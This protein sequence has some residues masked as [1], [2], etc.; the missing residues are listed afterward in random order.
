MKM[1]TRKDKEL[2]NKYDFLTISLLSEVPLGWLNL[3]DQMSAEIQEELDRSGIIDYTVVQAKEKFG[4]L[5]W[6]DFNG[7]SRINEIIGKYE[8]LSASTCCQ[9]GKIATKISLGWGCPWCD[10]CAK[11]V[12]GEFYS[13]V[14]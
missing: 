4:F 1:T 3:V 13:M 10:E 11:K 7:N 14:L 5:H 2:A 8:D 9:C 6:Y 12:G